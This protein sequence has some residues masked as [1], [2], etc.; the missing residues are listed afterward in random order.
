ML[1]ELL[2]GSLNTGWLNKD[3]IHERVYNGRQRLLASKHG[4][5][6]PKA[7]FNDQAWPVEWRLPLPS[8]DEI[9]LIEVETRALPRE[10]APGP[11]ASAWLGEVEDWA[12]VLRWLYRGTQRRVQGSWQENADHWRRLLSVLPKQRRERVLQMVLEGVDL[13]WAK[14][15]P[16]SLR[17]PVTGGC[18]RN[19]SS[20]RAEK[21]LVWKTLHEQLVEKAVLPWDCQGSDDVDVLPKGMFPIFTVGKPGTTKLRIVIDMRKLNDFLST[22]YCTVELPS[23]RGGRLRH[24]EFDWRVAF[25]MHASYYHAPYVKETRTWLGFSVSDDELPTE[26][27]EYLTRAW[28]QCRFGD[29]WVFVYAS[30]AMGASPSVADMQQ[31]MTAVVDAVSQSGTGGALGLRPAQWQG[32]VFIDDLDAKVD[33]G[34]DVGW[35]QPGQQNSGF[36][37]CMELGLRLLGVLLWLGFHINFKKSVLLP[38]LD[39]VFL[40]I[41]HDTRNM[42]FFL[43]TRRQKKLT[44]RVKDLLSRVRPGRYVKAKDVARV[45]GTIWSIQVVCHRAV[46]MCCREMIRT[47]TVMLRSPVLIGSSGFDMRRLLKK[48]WRGDVLWTAAAHR[49][50]I[51]WST[52]SWSDLWSPMGYDILVAGLADSVTGAWQG[53]LA[54]GTLI[55]ASDASDVAVGGGVFTPLGKGRFGCTLLVHHML[56]ARIR[57]ASSALRELRGIVETLVA[58]RPSRGARVLAVVDNQAVWRI[59]TRGSPIMELQRLA[60][61]CFRFCLERAILLHPLW[62]PRTSHIVRLC[63]DDS[64][65]ICGSNFSASSDLFWEA[66]RRAHRLWGSGFT[67]DRF[68][69]SCHVQPYDCP[70]KLPFSSWRRQAFSSGTNAL[71]QRW[72]G[73]VNWVN[74]PFALLGHVHAL[75][76]AQRAVAAVVVPRR[77]MPGLNKMFDIRAQ[78]VVGRWNL[79]P[80]DARCRMVGKDAP[81]PCR[82]GLSVVF[83]DFR[84]AADVEMPWRGKAAEQLR[85][86]WRLEGCSSGARRYFR[87]DGTSCRGLPGS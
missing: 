19:V 29:R 33:G 71:S 61:F 87:A 86:D 32:V 14:P 3:R 77:S 11:L 15:K 16:A 57:D 5:R 80:G 44:L 68:A 65:V 9:D 28:P 41:G 56:E 8:P 22:A 7:R 85:A 25:D 27:V 13:P 79:P 23:V 31:I 53:E 2:D 51:F 73:F 58:V 63:D 46:S 74:A 35:R 62:Q 20:V 18:P 72:Q 69:S 60:C 70:W 50:L 55:V 48:A 66:N 47:L 6:L 36:G 45:I 49:E 4:P 76:K 17:D 38:R 64:R 34:P 10:G 82:K 30:Y 84:R 12:C 24:G 83:L 81:P 52:V 26:A 54:P 67:Y 21:E 78:G 39:G 37:R 42:R 1:A 43:S 59:L 40:G 75:V